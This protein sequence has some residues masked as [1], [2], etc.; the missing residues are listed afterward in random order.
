MRGM[1]VRVMV[2]RRV[3]MSSR[4]VLGMRIV[5]MLA[6]V[7][8]AVIV[9]GMIGVILC[10]I[11]GLLLRA[12]RSVTPMMIVVLRRSERRQRAED[13]RG[14]ERG[15]EVHARPSSTRTSRIM[16]ASM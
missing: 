14:D 2:L 11:R 8:L 15:P 10:R 4:A 5:V 12:V 9:S 13:R 16:P 7:V 1:I 6:V 3:V